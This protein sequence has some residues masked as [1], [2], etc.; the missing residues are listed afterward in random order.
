MDIETK[1]LRETL[2]WLVDLYYRARTELIAYQ[3]AHA[4]LLAAG[5]SQEFDQLL[6]KSQ[7]NHS[8][9]LLA[10]HQTTRY[11][12][13]RLLTEEKVDATL[14]FLRNWKPSGLIP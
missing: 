8:P 11:T 14:E 2:L 1:Q 5:L 12:I 6:A 4:F 10:E 3:V 7:T 9:A 13:E